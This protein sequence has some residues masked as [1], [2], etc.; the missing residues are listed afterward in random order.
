M[1]M[2]VYVQR[3][4]I[5][6]FVCVQDIVHHIISIWNK[7]IRPFFSDAGACARGIIYACVHTYT[8]TSLHTN[9]TIS[10]VQGRK[11]H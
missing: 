8:H 7:S 10:A 11:V 9:S 6:M 2:L 1:R 4:C 5:G 3:H